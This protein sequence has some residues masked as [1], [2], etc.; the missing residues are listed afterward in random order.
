MIT[1]V[2]AKLP[3]KYSKAFTAGEK[4]PF[5]SKVDETLY[6][7]P[8]PRPDEVGLLP[9]IGVRDV[10]DF[11]TELPQIPH[12]SEKAEVLRHG[13]SY[14]HLPF[15][16]NENPSDDIVN[17]FFQ[18]IKKAKVEDTN[19]YAHCLHGRDRTGLM[20]ELYKIY[21][22]LSSGWEESLNRL[23]MQRYH[24]SSNGLLIPFLKEF[25]EKVK[26]GK[27]RV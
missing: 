22:G 16:S 21:N 11:S 2:S 5:Y 18:I 23:K 24:V 10:I 3:N 15:V 13:M 12:Y 14:H 4:P 19:V 27:F 6:R 9:N 7:G 1:K 20:V 26:S 17:T 8:R 25:S